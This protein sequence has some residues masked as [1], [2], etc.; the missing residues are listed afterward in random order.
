MSGHTYTHTHTHTYIHTHTHTHDNYSNP[1]CAHG[2]KINNID[3]DDEI[4]MT[5]RGPRGPN[6][7]IHKHNKHKVIITG[8]CVVFS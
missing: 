2:L 5:C 1:R 6:V 7:K 3:D 4:L 8:G